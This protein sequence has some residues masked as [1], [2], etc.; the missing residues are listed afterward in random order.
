MF[1]SGFD[2]SKLREAILLCSILVD[3]GE[4]VWNRWRVAS[5]HI[6][7]KIDSG[8]KVD[9]R[10]E[11]RVLCSISVDKGK[12]VLN[13]RMGTSQRILLELDSVLLGDFFFS[14]VSMALLFLVWLNS[15]VKNRW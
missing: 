7:S 12:L 8:F 3:G 2:A 5:W 15:I 4:F 10:V 14:F 6:L 9:R 13:D 11:T 1:F